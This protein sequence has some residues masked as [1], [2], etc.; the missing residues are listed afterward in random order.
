[1]TYSV[2]SSTNPCKHSNGNNIKRCLNSNVRCQEEC[3][4]SPTCIGYGAASNHCLL[5]MSSESCSDGWMSIPGE[6]VQ[7]ADDVIASSWNG[8][9]C[10]LKGTAISNHLSCSFA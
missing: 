9:S 5:Y 4:L 10:V 3:T 1:M 7:S 2:L 6:V 8:G